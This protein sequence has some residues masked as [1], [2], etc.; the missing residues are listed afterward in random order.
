MLLWSVGRKVDLLLP[1]AA[2]DVTVMRPFGTRLAV[3]AHDGGLLLGVDQRQYLVLSGMD[4]D[5]AKRLLG[6]AKI[7]SAGT[8]PK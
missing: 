8:A 5:Q 4:M 2:E 3:A 6:Q 7:A 1:V